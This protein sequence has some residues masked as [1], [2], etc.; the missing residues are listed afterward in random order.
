MTRYIFS[1]R[2]AMLFGFV[3]LLSLVAI[4]AKAH[5]VPNFGNASNGLISQTNEWSDSGK[6][7][8]TGRYIAYRQGDRI[9]RHDRDSGVD[10]VI[11]LGMSGATAND[12]SMKPEI[13]ADGTKIIFQSSANNLVPNDTNNATD[14]FV[15]DISTNVTTRVSTFSNGSQGNGGLSPNM[16]ANGSIVMFIGSEFDPSDPSIDNAQDLFSGFVGIFV[17]DL[18]TGQILRIDRGYDNTPVNGV[19]YF[20]DLSGNGQYVA[21]SSSA[22]NLLAPGVDT[23]NAT[24]IFVFDRNDGILE[25]IP[26]SADGSFPQIS[27]DGNIIAYSTSDDIVFAYNRTMDETTMVSVGDYGTIAQPPS[28]YVPMNFSLSGSGRFVAFSTPTSLQGSDDNELTDVYVHDLQTELSHLVSVGFNGTLEGISANGSNTVSGIN[29]NGQVIAFSSLATNLTDDVDTDGVS[30]QFIAIEQSGC[31]YEKIADL[32]LST[33]ESNLDYSEVFK[34]K[35]KDNFYSPYC[36]LT[37]SGS[38]ANAILGTNGDDILMGTN[39]DDVIFGFGGDDII[40]GLGGNDRICAG[41][42]DDFVDAG[43]GKDDVL[44]GD[45]ADHLVGGSG[46][47]RLHG[48]LKGDHLEGG[49]ERD[50]LWGG[51]GADEIFGDLGNDLIHGGSGHDTLHGGADDDLIWGDGNF[52][53]D[54][55]DYI[56]GNDTVYG[57]SGDDLIWGQDGNDTLHGQ[58]DNDRLF[59]NAGNDSLLGGA[60]TDQL[61]GGPDW[62]FCADTESSTSFIDCEF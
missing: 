39:G 18:A 19:S 40:N 48:G 42:G 56:I 15:R 52:T 57:G 61:W 60:G 28:L 20:A 1:N 46:E 31:P 32:E 35:K 27:H 30:D 26:D 11:D 55:P 49:S 43:S 36:C 50:D 53:T 45:G 38:A 16:S 12:G 24:D 25:R 44:G 7:S 4:T 34:E 29:F 33:K 21:F 62:D 58:G 8:Y 51:E 59:G 23:N 13:N 37:V 17:K 47:D 5:V 9:K 6:L 2:K 14:I 54:N 10:I 3:S 41:S 22:S